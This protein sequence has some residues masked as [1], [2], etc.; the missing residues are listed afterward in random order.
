[1][2]LT[3]SNCLRVTWDVVIQPSEGHSIHCLIFSCRFP[4]VKTARLSTPAFQRMAMVSTCLR[5]SP[6]VESM[7]EEKH[8]LCPV[9]CR[10]LEI[11]LS[12]DEFGPIK[13]CLILKVCPVLSS[14][15]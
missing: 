4:W 10:I 3:L 2:V 15:V 1:M 5:T 13:A 14:A 7:D 9:V 12:D 8:Q 11:T 6:R